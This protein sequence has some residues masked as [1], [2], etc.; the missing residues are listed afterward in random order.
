MNGR[1][2]E[3][4]AA[5]VRWRN[6]RAKPKRDLAPESSNRTWTGYTITLHDAALD[7]EGR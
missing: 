4:I 6:A 2:G 1:S 7:S 5:Y 3:A